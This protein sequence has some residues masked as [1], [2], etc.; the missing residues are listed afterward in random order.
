MSEQPL[1]DLT[2]GATGRRRP[3]QAPP[4]G[5]RPLVDASLV[6]LVLVLALACTAGLALLEVA[7]PS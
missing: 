6:V 1:S 3:T 2:L 4:G 5:D 7:L